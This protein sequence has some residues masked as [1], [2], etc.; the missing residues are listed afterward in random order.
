M[1]IRNETPLYDIA[2][3]IG[4]DFASKTTKAIIWGNGAKFPGQEVS[5]ATRALDG[6]QIKFI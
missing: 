5:L 1:V 3:R 6:M 2:A 4:E